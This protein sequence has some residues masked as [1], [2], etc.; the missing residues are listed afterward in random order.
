MVIRARWVLL[1]LLTAYGMI[2][3]LIRAADG[4]MYRAKRAGKNRVF[5]AGKMFREDRR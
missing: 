3:S 1:L 2:E 4:A 5:V